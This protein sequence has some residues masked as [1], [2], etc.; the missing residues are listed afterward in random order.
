MT[1]KQKLRNRIYEKY[2]GRCAYCG[3]FLKKGWHVDE[4]KPIIRNLKRDKNHKTVSDNTCQYPENLNENNQ[5]PSC[6][7]CNINKHSLSLENFRKSIE[8]F[9]VSLNRNSVQYKIAK[10][11]GLIQETGNK[12]IFYF[13]KCEINDV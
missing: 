7:S 6:P 1:K 5:M 12:V 3:E 4:L 13:E 9:I 11:Y 8:H 10:R 2:D